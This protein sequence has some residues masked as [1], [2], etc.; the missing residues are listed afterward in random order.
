MRNSLRDL[1]E[2]I[3]SDLRGIS[4]VGGDIYAMSDSSVDFR[5]A[6]GI[7]VICSIGA[8]RTTVT[9]A[10]DGKY[11]GWVAEMDDD[12]EWGLIEEILGAHVP[13]VRAMPNTPC[14]VN[15]G[16]TVLCPG[17]FAKPRHVE[18]ARSIFEP[19]GLVE[20]ID[21]EELM[22]GVTGLSLYSCIGLTPCSSSEVSEAV[23]YISIN[24]SA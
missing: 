12:P 22:D 21:S 5:L 7:S 19:V 10:L 9:I 8:L 17:K 23:R 16:M 4:S 24:P 6:T 15:E 18:T 3:P 1:G 2:A 20:V 13:V 11:A 14:L